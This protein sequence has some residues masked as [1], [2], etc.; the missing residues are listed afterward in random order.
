MYCNVVW[1]LKRTSG[2]FNVK[3]LRK[4]ATL[5]TI[6]QELVHF[7]MIY[8]RAKYDYTVEQRYY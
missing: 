1:R 8:T 5:S 2:I 7:K 6:Y 3:K 4:R